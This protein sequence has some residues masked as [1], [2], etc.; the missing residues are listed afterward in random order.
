MARYVLS[1]TAKEDLIRIHHFGVAKFGMAQAD[2]YFFSLFD[3]FERIAANPFAFEK[4]ESIKPG[5]HRC[6]AGADSIYFK[7]SADQATIQIITNI[8]RQDL[9]NALYK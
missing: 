9:N 7:I 8:S 4:V 5:Y 3:A 1:Q 2:K 6:V